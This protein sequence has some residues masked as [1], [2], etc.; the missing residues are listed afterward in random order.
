MTKNRPQLKDNAAALGARVIPKTNPPPITQWV[1]SFRFW[2]QIEF[3][4]CS[5]SNPKWFVS[6][7]QKLGELGNYSIDEFRSDPTAQSVWRYHE[8]N[9]SAK[10]IPIQR[11]VLTWVDE[12]YRN[13]EAEYPLMQFMISRALGRV[14]GF[15]D[16]KKVFQIVLLDPLHNIHPVKKFGYRVDK[17]YPLGCQYTSLIGQIEGLKKMSCTGS[18]CP[19]NVALQQLPSDHVPYNVLL[20]RVS[21]M[22]VGKVMSQLDA[23]ASLEDILEYGITYMNG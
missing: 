10:N 20:C 9:W 5:E 3:F 21:D 14:V 4:G 6:L 18:N 16:E 1:F 19:A 8:I 22:L 15:W 17:C 2:R 13:N 11:D 7:L 12:K 23:G